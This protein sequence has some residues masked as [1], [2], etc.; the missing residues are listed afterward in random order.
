MKTILIPVDYSAPSRL[1]ADFG[2]WLAGQLGA[3]VILLH[4]YPVAV[5]PALYTIPIQTTGSDET[6]YQQNGEYIQAFRDDL[7]R[8]HPSLNSVPVTTKVIPGSAKSAILSE[9][10]EMKADFIILG[11]SGASTTL[12][13]WL[14]SVATAV[15]LKAS[16]PVWVISGTTAPGRIRPLTYFADLEGNEVDCIQRIVEIARDL[17]ASTKVIHV[18]AS[19]SENQ[20]D[21]EP[22]FEKLKEAFQGESDIHF[23]Q[24]DDPHPHQRIENYIQHYNP[25]IV[26]L[27]HHERSFLD[28]VFHKSLIRHIVLTAKVPLLIIPKNAIRA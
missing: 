13:N 11:T 24:F 4:A 6:L 17:D 14:G 5:M 10:T 15:T 8:R 12:E 28:T 7:L 27:A 23:W 25:G 1:A 19:A 26:V 9:A 21:A 16:C 20:W 18:A 3:H 22:A 2:L